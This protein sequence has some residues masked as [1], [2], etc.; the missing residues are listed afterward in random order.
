M[1][2]RDRVVAAWTVP[3]PVPEL[4]AAARARLAHDWPTLA[5]ALHVLAHT[6]ES[7]A[8]DLADDLYDACAAALD[9]LTD[10]RPDLAVDHLRRAIRHY[11][12]DLD[13]YGTPLPDLI[14]LRHR[15]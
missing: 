3:G 5:R 8:R 15:R 1:N 12:A 9:A 10:R 4:H 11:H 14:E 2:A 13:R 7:S 6:D